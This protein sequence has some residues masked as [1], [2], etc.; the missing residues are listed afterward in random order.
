MGLLKHN[1]VNMYLNKIL[2][3]SLN[4]QY[5]F[6]MDT[7]MIDIIGLSIGFIDLLKRNVT[8]IY[9]INDYK[10]IIADEQFVMIIIIKNNNDNILKLLNLITN[11]KYIKNIQIYFSD[12]IND[13]ILLKI[14]E[15]NVFNKITK[16]M[17][18]YLS[19]YT[20]EPFIFKIYD[21]KYL[22][23][24]FLSYKF[25][26]FNLRLNNN[27]DYIYK[28]LDKHFYPIKQDEYILFMD[29]YDDP[30]VPLLRY[31]NYTSILHET[32][33]INNNIICLK[34]DTKIV[35]STREDSYYNEHI[36]TQFNKIVTISAQLM[37]EHTTKVK[38]LTNIDN[39][40]LNST[41]ISKIKM[42][43][44]MSRSLNNHIQLQTII[45]NG[46]EQQILECE[47]EQNIIMGEKFNIT[48]DATEQ[49]NALHYIRY[50]KA[51]NDN[52][53]DENLFKRLKF[54]KLNIEYKEQITNI[55]KYEPLLFKLLNKIINKNK[56]IKSIMVYINGGMTYEEAHIVYEFK[57][58]YN[59]DIIIG[60]THILNS[61]MFIQDLRKI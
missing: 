17:E 32:F 3:D 9:N 40:K 38:E 39:D 13:E 21:I 42:L 11:T 52:F 60:S 28:E 23:H 57:K 56:K 1:V 55:D 35:M 43:K 46:V 45:A 2:Y 59:I 36:F 34:D 26:P 5:I 10:N 7:V 44:Q 22:Y 49:M 4:N 24:V 12:E 8:N 6:I 16:I 25:N 61:K 53:N 54:C 51:I 19:H 41:I 58:L 15:Y 48:K 50:G 31:W 33:T 47:I 30:I 29:R 18:I 14:G 27:Y 37:N 20:L